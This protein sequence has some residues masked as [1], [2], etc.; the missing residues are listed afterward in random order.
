MLTIG[1]TCE[2]DLQI[3]QELVTQQLLHEVTVFLAIVPRT[4][5]YIVKR[6]MRDVTNEP[7]QE[8]ILITFTDF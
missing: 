8:H 1:S 2:S 3:L 7:R 4:T 5:L 6:S